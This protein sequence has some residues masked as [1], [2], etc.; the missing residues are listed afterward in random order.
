VRALR[1]GLSHPK[2]TSNNKEKTMAKV[3][4]LK[5]HLTNILAGGIEYEARQAAV[6]DVM[7]VVHAVVFHAARAKVL[8]D[9]RVRL[10][11]TPMKERSHGGNRG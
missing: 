1:G 3:T 11:L 8:H 9:A 5:D 4:T 7:G 2:V 6:A 10:L